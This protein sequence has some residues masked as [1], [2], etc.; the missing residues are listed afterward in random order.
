[1][2]NI[3]LIRSTVLY[4]GVDCLAIQLKDTRAHKFGTMLVQK[5]FLFE[6]NTTN[7]TFRTNLKCKISIKFNK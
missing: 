1:M 7:R 5:N 2:L 6:Q 3:V 4:L